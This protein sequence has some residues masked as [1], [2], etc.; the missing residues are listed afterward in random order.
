[1]DWG[2]ALLA[3]RQLT[4][5]VSRSDEILMFAFLE[6]RRRLRRDDI[7]ALL[8]DR[9]LKPGVTKD[10]LESLPPDERNRLG[11]P[12]RIEAQLLDLWI[13]NEALVRSPSE[14]SDARV[15]ALVDGYHFFVYT[16]LALTGYTDSDLAELQGRIKAR[17][18]QYGDAITPVLAGGDSGAPF[19]L[20]RT[21]AG[22]L[23][24]SET[25]DPATAF[26]LTLRLTAALFATCDLLR[27]ALPHVEWR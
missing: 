3:I 17:Y 27:N 25:N 1:M 13:V 12:S 24:K 23:F 19:R 22:N 15:Q 10:I 7:V 2:L 5:S 20:A 4:A 11:S 18:S 26:A 21:V 6:R 14:L 8:A 16:H 9:V